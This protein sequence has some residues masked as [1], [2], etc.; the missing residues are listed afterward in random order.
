MTSVLEG[1]EGEAT[2]EDH[3]NVKWTAAAMYSAGSDSTAALVYVFFL[4][5]ALY[6]GK[7]VELLQVINN[8]RYMIRCS[9]ESA[10]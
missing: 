8:S 2:E 7:L 6:P 1:Y 10:G 9:E 3:Y 4:A 5:M